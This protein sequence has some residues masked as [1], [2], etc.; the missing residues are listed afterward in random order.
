MSETQEKVIAA[1]KASLILSNTSRDVK[2]KALNEIASSLW[3]ESNSVIKAASKDVTLAKIEVEEGRLPKPVLDRLKVDESKLRNIV[4]MV[5]SVSNLDDPVN[6][7]L[8]CTE[9]DQEFELYKVTCPIGVVG[10]VFESR[11]DVLPQ[12]SSL[13]LKSGN[14]VILKGGH[15]ASNVN[16]ELFKIVNEAS[17]SSGIPEGWIQILEERKDILD[18]LKLDKSVDLIIPRGSNDFVKFVQDNTRIPV[19]GHS[20][21]VCNLYVDQKANLNKAIN[22][23]FDAKVQYPSVCNSLDCLLVHRDIARTFLP[24]IMEKF[25]KAGVVVRG[26]EN[27]KKILDHFQVLAAT[28]EDWGKEYLDLIIAIKVVN[29]GEEAIEYINVY[30]SGHTDSIITE[31]KQMAKQFLNSVDSSTVILNAST[32]FSDGYR[33]GLGAEVGISTSKI[34]AR[35]PVGLEGLITYKYILLGD[36]NTVSEYV[37][38]NAKNFRHKDLNKKLPFNNQ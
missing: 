10:V 24:K 14:A 33:Y 36:G 38:P 8:N 29:N 13:C 34:H 27:T 31:D 7:T 26:C 30:G 21:G 25:E 32:R 19:L 16:R 3:R 28:N 20:A 17:I 15:E 12:I 9:L 6:K 4:E 22:I 37:G 18:L 1:K 5:K 11:P 35:G 23:A 2:D